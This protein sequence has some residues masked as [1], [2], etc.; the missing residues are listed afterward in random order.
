MTRIIFKTINVLYILTLSGHIKGIHTSTVA[1]L[2]K[3]EF[4]HEF[5]MFSVKKAIEEF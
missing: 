2:I 3:S 1:A 4:F 5:E